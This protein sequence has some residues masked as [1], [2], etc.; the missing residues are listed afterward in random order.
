M[1]MDDVTM[2][3]LREEKGIFDRGAE[4]PRPTRKHPHGPQRELLIQQRAATV[5]LHPQLPAT[6]AWTYDGLLPGPVVVVRAGERVQ[7]THDHDIAGPLPY[8]HVVVDGEAGGTMNDAGAGSASSDPADTAEADHAA[9]LHAW[10]V[11]HLHG[12]PNGPDSDGWAEN[13]IGVGDQRRDEYQFLRESWPMT[14][15]DGTRTAFR[16][17]A[18]PMFWYH[19]HG[20]GV[21]RFNVYAGLAGAW[22]VRDP[23]ESHLGLPTDPDREIPLVLADRNLDT[24]DG[25]ADGVLDGRVLHKVQTDVRECFAPVNLVNGLIW[26]RCAVS[27]RVHRLRILNGSNARTYRLH[28]HAQQEP[29]EHPGTPLPPAAVQQIGTDGGLLG[30]AV[31]L[32]ADGLLLAPGERA[33][34]LVDFGL[35]EKKVRHVVVWNS[36]PAPFQGTPPDPTIPVGSPD[37]NGFLT[38]PQLMRFDLDDR[39]PS[40]HLH[41]RPVAGMALDP[42]FRRV[43]T[44]HRELPADHGHTLIALLEEEMILRD[45]HGQPRRDADGNVLTQAMLF[46]HE[47]VDERLAGQHGCNMYEQ[48]V[49]IVDPADPTAI[50]DGRAGIRLTL[51]GDGTHYVTVGKRFNDTT[52]AMATQGAWHQWK[53]INLSPDTHPFHIHLSQFQ[54]VSRKLLT[55]GPVA[56]DAPR[57]LVF[58]AT[59]DGVLDDNEKGWKDTFRVNPGDRVDDTIV[60]AE[61]VTVLGCLAAHSGRYMYHCHI[62]EHE[63]TEMMRPFTVLPADLM[64]FMDGHHH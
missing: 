22:L 27:R 42:E 15:P 53:V 16:A 17:G 52:M 21:T 44:D 4:M 40:P 56:P 32:P 59:A 29:D 18:A 20:M 10:T 48:R 38:T 11:V 47:M 13:V 12:A 58:T 7:V 51:P 35:L 61:M 39:P 3:D 14:A 62:L 60:T 64:A 19:D 43:P 9:A 25:T 49:P 55:A 63:D 54:A 6:P 24:A 36:A 45:E 50:T 23:I 26:P 30:A 31:D 37:P 2:A 28:F 8:R 41:G 5:S 34:V 1:A 46:L 33:D 57:E